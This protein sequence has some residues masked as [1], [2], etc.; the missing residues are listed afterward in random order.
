M[1]TG[2]SGGA[3]SVV[4]PGQVWSVTGDVFDAVSLMMAWFGLSRLI[5]VSVVVVVL[6]IVWHLFAKKV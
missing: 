5:T 6:G 3:T 4:D 1:G 2:H